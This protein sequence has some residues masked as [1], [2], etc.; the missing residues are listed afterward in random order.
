MTNKKQ[1]YFAFYK[2]CY[3]YMDSHFRTGGSAFGIG[4]GT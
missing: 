3:A 4:G 1:E 2:D